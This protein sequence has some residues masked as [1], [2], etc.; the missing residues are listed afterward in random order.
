MNRD[1]F[2][3]GYKGHRFD[4]LDTEQLIEHPQ[5]PETGHPFSLRNGSEFPVAGEQRPL[6][7]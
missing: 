5:H 4:R 3:T 1:R 2:K 7:G 6:A